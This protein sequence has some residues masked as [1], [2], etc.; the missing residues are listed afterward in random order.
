MIAVLATSFKMMRED[1]PAEYL[2]AFLPCLIPSL[3]VHTLPMSCL[4][5]TTLTYSR[6]SSDQE[7]QA[8]QW[9]GVRLGTLA[10]PAL[11]LGAGASLACAV[12][13][14]Q[15][16]PRATARF[17]Y[18]QEEAARRL[19]LILAATSEPVFG[20]PTQK[21]YISGFHGDVF[22]GVTVMETQNS[23][24]VQV[25]NAAEAEV[26]YDPASRSM[27]FDLRNGSLVIFDP[28]HPLGFQEITFEQK[29]LH[30]AYDAEI[31]V[32]KD[33]KAAT[34]REIRQALLHR[35]SGGSVD[36][37]DPTYSV[38]G[39]RLYIGGLKGDEGED[40]EDL[41]L[42]EELQDRTY[43][44]YRSRTG[45]MSILPEENLLRL[46]MGP[47][48][49]QHLEGMVRPLRILT[50]EP[51]GGYAEDLPL[52][53]GAL[54]LKPGDHPTT[55]GVR[56][57]LRARVQDAQQI[58]Y[59]A[60]VELQERMAGALTALCFVMVGVPLGVRLRHG[61]RL[62]SFGASLL[63]VFCLYYPAMVAGKEL[64][65][66][67]RLPAAVGLWMPDLLMVGTGAFLVRALKV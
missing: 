41:V 37:G 2:W 34:R 19:P 57:V 11:L 4:F 29:D 17:Q 10:A 50:E 58:W 44:A 23:V 8:A 61:N 55:A 7:I 28:A 9:S 65:L 62:V 16:L 3:L 22:S 20:T 6:L 63:V 35:L 66:T 12:L 25:L 42:F 38:G 52:E 32:W 48:V 59:R 64:S 60:K 46:E 45:R 26:R 15:V 30:V 51:F 40:A 27:T 13:N 54:G 43:H 14:D 53:S 18:L 1:L 36:Q 56:A 31:S 5:A 47:G 24:T 33:W 21:M 67:G 39:R 49:H